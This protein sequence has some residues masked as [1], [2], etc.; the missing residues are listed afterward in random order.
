MLQQSANTFCAVEF[1]GVLPNQAVGSEITSG[2]ADKA[3]VGAGCW[4][5]TPIGI[6]LPTCKPGS[7]RGG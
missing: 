2:Q 4:F 7:A 1:G 3:G 6:H 5:M